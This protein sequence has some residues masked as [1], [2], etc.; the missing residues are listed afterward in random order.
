MWA[1]IIDTTAGSRYEPE[2]VF[3]TKEKRGGMGMRKRAWA[4]SKRE[5]REKRRKTTEKKKKS[6]EKK[7]KKKKKKH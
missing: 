6:P 3:E 5:E 4:N 7:K 2:V 1:S